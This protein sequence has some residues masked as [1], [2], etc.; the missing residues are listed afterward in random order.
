MVECNV[1]STRFACG[2]KYLR[3]IRSWVTVLKHVRKLAVHV[4]SLAGLRF[5]LHNPRTWSATSAWNFSLG[6]SVRLIPLDCCIGLP[7][8]ELA[9]G[10]RLTCTMKERAS[11]LRTE[12]SLGSVRRFGIA[13]VLLI[14]LRHVLEPRVVASASRC[15]L[16]V[17]VARLVLGETLLRRQKLCAEFTH[18]LAAFAGANVISSS[19]LSGCL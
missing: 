2:S 6:K 19:R 18:Y 17:R 16:P 7:R 15:K 8:L 4:H 10:K 14:V 5:Y 12:V 13:D 3:L 9:A 1:S 11:L